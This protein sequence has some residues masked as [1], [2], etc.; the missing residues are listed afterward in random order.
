MFRWD[1]YQWEECKIRC[2]CRALG[3]PLKRRWSRPT[4]RLSVT[5]SKSEPAFVA[6]AVCFASF[7]WLFWQGLTEPAMLGGSV[8]VGFSLG[9]KTGA[10]LVRVLGELYGA[11]CS[12]KHLWYPEPP[13]SSS[14]HPSSVFCLTVALTCLTH[15]NTLGGLC[16]STVMKRHWR[17]SKMSWFQVSRF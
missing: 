17:L 4:T 13:P 11:L 12:E 10:A 9:N 6:G 8:N 7:C 15:L 16:L 3:R 2:H 5:G 14:H 1:R